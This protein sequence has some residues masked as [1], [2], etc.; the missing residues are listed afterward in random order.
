MPTEEVC[1][2]V[3]AE[4]DA[5][6]GP[7]VP[8][9]LEERVKEKV[10]WKDV[11]RKKVGKKCS[12]SSARIK[13][14]LV[15]SIPI[16]KWLPR[17][18]FKDWIIGDAMSGLIVGILLVPQSIAY[19]LLAE[20]DPIYGLYTSFFASI[21]Y[22]LLGTSRHISVGMFGVLCLLVGQVVDRELTLAGYPSDTNQTTLGNVD[23]STGPVCDRS[24]YAVMVAATLTFTAGVY[25]VLMGLLQVGFVSVYLSDSLLSGFATG[26]SLTILTSQIK[27]FLGLHLPRVQGWGSLI[28]TWISLFKN[29]GHTNLCDLV[30]SVLCLLVLV[31]TK[32]LNDR[33]KAKLK[34]PIPFELFVVIA[35]TL[36]SHF[37]LFEETYGSDVAGN[38]PTGFMPPQLPNWSLIPNIAVDAFSIAIVGFAITVSLS[39]MFAKK[40]GYMVDPNQE[41]YAI[42]FCNIIPS[43]FRCFTT[44]AAL[45]KTL[46]KES[47]GC[48]TQ[49]SGLVT[50]LVLLLVLLVIAPAFYSLQ[51]CVL[52]VIIVVNLRGALRKFGDIPQMWRVN[53][54]DTIIWLITM[55][56]SALV[57]TELG[58][59]VGVLVSAFCVLG[60]TQSAQV[61]QL[62][63][64]GDRELFEDLVSSYKGLQNQPGV[65]VFRYEA[66]IYYANQALFKK[67]LYRSVGLDP[68]KEKARRRKLDKQRNQKQ[69]GE[70]QKQ[71]M[72]VSTNMYLLQYN[73][74]HT[75]VIDCSP[76]LFLDT[77]GVNALKEVCKDYKGLGVDVLLVQCNPSVIDSLRRGGYYDPKKGTKDIQFHTLSDAV[78]YA[79]SL[80]SQ[81]GDCDTVV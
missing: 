71:E 31:P 6:K 22:T 30:T 63:Q 35:A 40:H 56:T 53:H 26:A 18:Q 20:Q 45:T 7:D 14:L 77:A 54:V 19:S 4:D 27:Y 78:S 17:Y 80:K 12:C 38:I 61:R 74:L 76:V 2:S 9:L 32:E 16:V 25:Q 36:A 57:N 46:V 5:K 60:R 44:S 23:N 66:P 52:A 65:A 1:D 21:I 15:D 67:S 24:C 51:K 70:D 69:G 81:N 55:A 8:F 68:L 75:L 34:A 48:Q 11:L 28:K 49:L 50:A 42:G 33:F 37:G 3:S 58:L 64:A 59:L 41:M 47:T 79:Q 10:S 29:L 62:G 72:D 39:E 13:A 73:S 43:F